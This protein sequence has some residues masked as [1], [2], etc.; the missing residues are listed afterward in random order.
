MLGKCLEIKTELTEQKVKLPEPR[1]TEI[2]DSEKV[3]HSSEEIFIK[4]EFEDRAEEDIDLKSLGESALSCIECHDFK[5]DPL[6]L[7]K[8]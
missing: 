7:N 2:D 3:I 5:L 8:Y 4:D 6:K 1:L